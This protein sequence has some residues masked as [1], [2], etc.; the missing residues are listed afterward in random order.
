MV[1]GWVIYSYALLVSNPATALT[2]PFRF[3][4]KRDAKLFRFPKSAS[5]FL[6]EMIL[7]C[8]TT[9]RLAASRR[10]KRLAHLLALV[11]I[12]DSI[13]SRAAE[14]GR[15]LVRDWTVQS[16]FLNLPVKTGAPKRLAT[17]SADGV[18]VREFEIEWAPDKPDF[19]VFVDLHKFRGRHAS[20]FIAPKADGASGA[21]KLTDQIEQNENDYRES[22]RPQFHFT[23]R[24]G[25][26]NDPNGLVFYA[27]EY[28]LFYQHNPYGWNWGN[29]HWGHAISRD[30][31]HWEELGDALF[32]DNMG[33][34]FSGSAVI[35]ETN[36]AGFGSGGE[37]PLVCVYTAAGGTSAA[38]KNQPFTQCLAFSL[39]R[40]RTFTKYSGNPVLAHIVGG[41]RDPKVFWHRPQKK[42]VMA[43][44]LDKSDYA[45]FDSRDLKSWKR[46]SGV[47]IPGT[48]ECPEFFELP[49]SGRAGQARWIFY[50]G[51]GRYLIGTFDGEKFSAES[52]PH[53]LNFGNCFY[54]SQT[55]NGIPAEDG[56]RIMIGWGRVSFPGMPFNQMMD[57]PVELTLRA[58][59]EGVRLLVNPIREIE[60]LR[61]NRK[62]YSAMTLNAGESRLQT[63]ALE[64]AEIIFE[65]APGDSSE[66]GL[67]VRGV[68]I[69]YNSSERA[70][71]CLGKRAPLDLVNGMLALHLLIDRGSI[72]IFANGGR[73]YM[74]MGVIL[75]PEERSLNVFSKGGRARLV[76]AD[77]YPLKSI[78]AGLGGRD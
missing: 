64:T 53:E 30:L 42:W 38:S 72:E 52:G 37:K 44:Y 33:T 29:M 14:P 61:G 9:P 6:R 78:W 41:N 32:P 2:I 26:N 62:H 49:V 58:A 57:F 25:W 34:M 15:E 35:D 23:S 18:V 4:R 73:V 10:V 40:G 13:V 63:E 51:N 46:L 19:W 22:L 48:S 75:K 8:K 5:G 56:R 66:C 1:N 39:D 17:L 74:P 24:R 43:L 69:V 55:F 11:L 3:P 68:P 47:T 76:S 21:I 54:A 20:L 7:P 65:L 67:I 16:N 50:G 12:S 36:S 70:L 77:V 45:L 60:K 71:V 28:H 27:G 31:V 59:E